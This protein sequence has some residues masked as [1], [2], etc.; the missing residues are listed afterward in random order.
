[1]EVN[2]INDLLEEIKNKC[3]DVNELVRPLESLA[4][5]NNENK[6][7]TNDIFESVNKLLHSLYKMIKKL[8]KYIKKESNHQLEV[9]FLK[10]LLVRYRRFIINTIVLSKSLQSNLEDQ[11]TTKHYLSLFNKLIKH[12]KGIVFFIEI[13]TEDEEENSD[14]PGSKFKESIKNLILTKYLL[15]IEVNKV[16][17][18]SINTQEKTKSDSEPMNIPSQLEQIKR[19]VKNLLSLINLQKINRSSFYVNFFYSQEVILL[20]YM[21]EKNKFLKKKSIYSSEIEVTH[22][23]EQISLD[24]SEKLMN[25]IITH[26]CNCSLR[27]SSRPKIPQRPQP[28]KAKR[29]GSFILDRTYLT[30]NLKLLPSSSEAYLTTPNIK[31]KRTN[32]NQRSLPNFNPPTKDEINQP[33]ELTISSAPISV[34]A[35]ISPRRHTQTPPIS[36]RATSHQEI[37]HGGVLNENAKIPETEPDMRATL[38][39]KKSGSRRSHRFLAKFTF[40]P[41]D[42]NFSF[43]ISC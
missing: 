41:K 26:F 36:P 40:N 18:L 19:I 25:I 4:E 17:K 8:T 1:M 9:A 11:K 5:P 7:N 3:K 23:G 34:S 38:K 24:L 29:K 37:I 27:D 28:T 10:D 31:L 22:R 32:E 39:K 30:T 2:S 6:P 16:I 33:K 12:G 21:D 13:L 15:E 35:I 42:V 20:D 43:Y 14:L